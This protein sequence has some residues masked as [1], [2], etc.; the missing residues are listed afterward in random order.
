MK[1]ILG[2]DPEVSI[3][4]TFSLSIKQLGAVRI[5]I[6]ELILDAL[7]VDNDDLN[8]AIGDSEVLVT[9]T[10]VFFANHWN[11]QIHNI[12]CSIVETILSSD[13]MR[14]KR[15][16]LVSAGLAPK[17][18]LTI[19]EPMVTQTSGIEIRKGYMGHVTKISNALVK[20]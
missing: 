5:K 19:A 13:C 15:N 12:Y 16:V 14:L 7:K 8:K 4:M 3:P 1:A 18:L 6:A 20:S 11:T 10:D 17:I 2:S 9:L